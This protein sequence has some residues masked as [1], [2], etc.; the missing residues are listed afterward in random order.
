MAKKNN[1]KDVIYLMGE[2]SFREIDRTVFAEKSA[3][4]MGFT[5][6]N[7]LRE[8]PK[9]KEV[10]EMIHYAKRKL[11]GEQHAIGAYANITVFEA[12]NRI[13]SDLVILKGIKDLLESYFKDDADCRIT[14]HLGTAHVKGE[15]DF[16]IHSRG[17]EFHG[18]AFNVADRKSVV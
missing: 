2:K 14:M 1:P 4:Y 9:T 15:G 8:L 13:A 18:E 7:T 5:K 3:Q 11:A 10:I 16:I 6:T 17:N 12:A